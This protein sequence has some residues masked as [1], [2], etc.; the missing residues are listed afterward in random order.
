MK[1]AV[2][3][4]LPLSIIGLI[5]YFPPI[6]DLLNLYFG[7]PGRVTGAVV[8][9]TGWALLLGYLAFNLGAQSQKKGS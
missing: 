4:G 3:L 5:L 9:A 6:Q 1:F 7:E 8:F 2:I